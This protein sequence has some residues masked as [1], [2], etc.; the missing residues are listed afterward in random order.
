MA[1]HADGII[2]LSGCLSG[3][4]CGHL[5]R[6]DLGAA[7]EELDRLSEIFGPED[8]YLELQDSG[9]PIQQ[10]INQHLVR[11]SRETG[12]TLVATGDVH[13][14]CHQDADAH[15]ALLAI[16]TRDVLSNPNR[17]R[18]ETKE[19]FL[20]SGEEMLRALPD[21]PEALA[22]TAEVAE[23][24]ASLELVLGDPKLPRFPVPEGETPSTYLERRCREGLVRRCG[25]HRHVHILCLL[26]GRHASDTS[27][28][29]RIRPN[30]QIFARD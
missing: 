22:A 30:L 15:E 23:R 21:H 6:D 16:Q 14:V 18:F 2:A 19:F 20:K 25:A 5:E 4:I 7:R 9:L 8:V 3:T 29:S 10:R 28:Q 24:C 27:V 17:F 26:I 13:Y 1:R 12:R 11:L